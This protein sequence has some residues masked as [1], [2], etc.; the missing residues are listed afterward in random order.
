M[1]QSIGKPSRRRS[2][3][4]AVAVLGV[5][6]AGCGGGGKGPAS[7]EA[8]NAPA[9]PNATLRF[10]FA[11]D[12]SKNYDPVT[13]ANPFVTTFLLPAYDR[14]LD[15]DAKGK[16]VPMLAE[17][18]ALSDDGLTLTLTLREGVVFHDGTPFDATAVKANIERAKTA[19]RSTLKPELAVVTA[20]DVVDPRTVALKLS[21]PAASLPAQLADRAGMMVSP[22]AFAKPDLALA[23]VGTGPYRVVEGGQPGVLVVYERFDE[24]WNASTTAEAVKR[25]E[26]HIQLNP[27]TRLRS[28][29]AGEFDATMINLDQ[30]KAAS[31]TKL[32]VLSQQ[33]AGAFQIYLN[34]S[35][36]PALAKP[37]VRAAL[38]MALDRNGISQ[39]LLGGQCT[40]SAQIFPKDYWAAAPDLGPDAAK[41]DV[42]AAK[43]KLAD[44]GFPDGFTMSMTSVNV[45]PYST[46][47]EAVAAQLREI[48][49]TVELKIAE[50]AQ[51]MAGFVAQKS[52]DSYVSLWPGAVDPAQTVA[53]LYLP[54]GPLNPG[55]APDEEIT[56]LAAEGQATPN[57]EAREKVYQKIAARAVAVTSHLPICS[58]PLLLMASTKVRGLTSTVAGA[59]DLRAVK[60]AGSAP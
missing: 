42:A 17:K 33:G 10:S 43:Q 30:F 48:G 23:P 46:V 45:A 4:A 27:E 39:A 50:P 1:F 8:A 40:P 24:Y 14:L 5:V 28:T 54:G 49:V 47:T 2:A 36:N 35:K 21:A 12:A 52:V 55:G 26:L 41:F 59:I 32:Q 18:T 3:L 15:I 25:I 6:L 37:E 29:G 60:I 16:V 31:D 38:S 20:V 19:E 13:A 57:G 44:A 11:T 34:M 7:S 56:R 53:S 51:V 9:D 22:Q 58:A